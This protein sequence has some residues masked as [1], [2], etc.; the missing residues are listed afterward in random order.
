VEDLE[1]RNRDL[2]RD[3]DELKKEVEARKVAGAQSAATPRRLSPKG[4]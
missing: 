3:L 2:R 1:R 4:Q